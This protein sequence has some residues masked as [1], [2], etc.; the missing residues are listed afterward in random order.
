MDPLPPPCPPGQHA[1]ALALRTTV[2]TTRGHEAARQPRTVPGRSTSSPHVPPRDFDRARFDD[3]IPRKMFT[4]SVIPYYCMCPPLTPS[5]SHAPLQQ[6]SLTQGSA[7][8]AGHTTVAKLLRPHNVVDRHFKRLRFDDA[9]ASLPQLL[10][11]VQGLGL[12]AAE[13]INELKRIIE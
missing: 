2:A 7:S 10:R 3:A 5:C 12:P 11:T 13:G 9:I 4:V 6:I 8:G 1:S